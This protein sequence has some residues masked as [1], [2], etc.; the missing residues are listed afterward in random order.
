[1]H[2]NVA[3]G[4]MVKR[5]RL[6]DSY[7]LIRKLQTYKNRSIFVQTTYLGIMLPFH[8][9]SL[10]LAAYL[11]AADYTTTV[12]VPGGLS[13]AL[14]GGLRNICSSELWRNGMFVVVL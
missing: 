3:L 7:H 8:A 1:M 6:M 5:K 10:L 2:F 4:T 9:I 11:C 12:D 14:Y 13:N